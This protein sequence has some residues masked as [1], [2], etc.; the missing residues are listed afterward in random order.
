[1]HYST[2]VVGV[3]T[4]GITSPGTKSLFAIACGQLLW[5]RL[6]I[7]RV[8]RTNV[9]EHFVR[10]DIGIELRISFVFRLHI[11]K[12]LDCRARYAEHECADDGLLCA[13][14]KA[15]MENGT[16]DGRHCSLFDGCL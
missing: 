6:E 14:H 2:S 5:T 13:A 4:S 11:E 3:S 8:V 7:W 9:L 10:I 15:T 16:R 12:V 1:M